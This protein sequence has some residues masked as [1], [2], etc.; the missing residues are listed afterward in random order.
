MGV[1]YMGKF[2]M[3][4]SIAFPFLCSVGDLNDFFGDALADPVR[5]DTMDPREVK[6]GT[7]F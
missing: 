4:S 3:G 6:R 7:V 1:A 5:E 2:S